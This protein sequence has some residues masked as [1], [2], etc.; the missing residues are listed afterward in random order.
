MNGNLGLF[1]LLAIFA[2][3]CAK[4]A[5]PPPP[6]PAKAPPPAVRSQP[7]PVAKVTAVPQS[8]PA[9]GQAIGA[10]AAAAAAQDAPLGRG[11]DGRAFTLAGFRG[12]PVLALFWTSRCPSCP[13]ELSAVEGLRRQYE[14]QGLAV[15]AVNVGDKAG[16]AERFI[17]RQKDAPRMIQ[18][19]DA[20]RSAARGLGVRAV[21]TTLLFD[22]SGRVVRRY[23][24]YSGLDVAELKRELNQLLAGGS[25]RG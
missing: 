9:S 18:L 13:G 12:R 6:P 25:G 1:L 14:K 7:D 17:A 10:P 19:L 11:R 20:D 15:L 3:G 24:G 8:A 21:P 4:T 5:R 23:G 16:E 22:A 2:A